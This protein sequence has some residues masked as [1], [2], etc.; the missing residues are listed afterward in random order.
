MDTSPP[1]QIEHKY[2]KRQYDRHDKKLV[3]LL[4]YKNYNAKTGQQG[5]AKCGKENDVKKTCQPG[6]FYVFK[7]W[8][9]K[10]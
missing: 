8:R 10:Y 4:W 7:N 3:Y 9:S 6:N 2:N 1:H 5:D